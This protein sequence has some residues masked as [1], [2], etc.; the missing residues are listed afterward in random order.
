MGKG[1][2]SIPFLTAISLKIEKMYKN[3][4]LLQ[5]SWRRGFKGSSE[6]KRLDTDDINTCFFSALTP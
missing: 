4:A 5:I 2:E 3:M 6:C 1:T